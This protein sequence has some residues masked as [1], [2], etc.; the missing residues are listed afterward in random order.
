[1]P[2]DPAQRAWL[3]NHTNVSQLDLCKAEPSL[4]L[5]GWARL[6]GRVLAT[7]QTAFLAGQLAKRHADLG[8]QDL[9]ALGLQLLE[10][11]EAVSLSEPKERGTSF[12]STSV[13][14]EDLCDDKGLIAAAPLPTEP[15]AA[16]IVE[17]GLVP[18]SEAHPSALPCS[19]SPA[20]VET[21]QRAHAAHKRFA[22]TSEST[23]AARPKTPR[24]SK[25]LDPNSP[26]VLEKLEYLD[27]LVFAAINGCGR[28]L[29]AVQMVWPEVL[30]ELGDELVAES[31]EQYLR[32]SLS[33]WEQCTKPDGV[34][35]ATRAIQALDVLCVLFN[36]A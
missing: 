13:V 21:L 17:T 11:L 4:P 16:P 25:A 30:A 6:V 9:Q 22:G 35:D 29:E 1:L 31:R 24:P 15:P 5:E 10:D 2:S 32:Y 8:A 34:R 27:D 36:E 3:A 26:V 23:N 28:S 33:I 18:S 7:E 14:V 12:H 19:S 20:H